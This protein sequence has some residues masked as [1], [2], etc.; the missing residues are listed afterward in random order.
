M[1]EIG[2]VTS[3]CFRSTTIQ[4]KPLRLFFVIHAD[5]TFFLSFERRRRHPRVIYSGMSSSPSSRLWVGPLLL[6]LVIALIY[7]FSLMPNSPPQRELT[8][9]ID[10]AHHVRT[11]RLG[12]H[13]ITESLNEMKAPKPR[14]VKRGEHQASTEEVAVGEEVTLITLTPVDLR[15]GRAGASNSSICPGCVPE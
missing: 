5:T 2:P 3:G 4:T 9:L 1:F 6:I 13:E 14:L 10:D 11:F 15:T 12:D 8:P 7:I